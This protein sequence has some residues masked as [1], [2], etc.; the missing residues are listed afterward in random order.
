MATWYAQDSNIPEMVQAIFYAMV[1]NEAEERGTTYRISAMPDVG[2]AAAAS[3]S[4]RVL[5]R[6]R[7]VQAQGSPSFTPYEPAY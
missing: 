1:V 7:R 5:V 3:G 6:E 2:P 4:L